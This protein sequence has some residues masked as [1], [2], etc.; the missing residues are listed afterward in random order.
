M[1]A[2]LLL[3]HVATSQIITTIAGTGVAAFSGDGG[4]ATAAEIQYPGGVLVDGSGNVY[5]SDRTNQRIRKIATTVII[6]TIAGNG[7]FSGGFGG[8]TGD[9]GPATAAELNYPSTFGFDPAGNM[10]IGDEQNNRLRKVNTSGIISTVAGTGTGTFNLASGPATTVNI[11]GPKI[12]M[13]NAG[14]IYVADK[15]QRIRKIDPAGML[16]TICGHGT[17]GFSGDGGP[18]TAAVFDL[19]L[20]VA[21]DPMGNIYFCDLG[22]IRVRKINTSGIISTVAG[23]GTAGFS[24]DG[25]PA[26]ACQLNHPSELTVDFLGNLYISDGYNTRIR[27]VNTAGIITTIAGIGIGG[28]SGDG[29]PATAADIAGPQGLAVDS[30]GNLYFADYGN[31]RIRKISSGNHIPA[32]AGGHAQ[33]LKV[34]KNA[35]A[36]VID[37]LLTIL[38]ADI[39]QTEKWTLVSGPFHGSA[40]VPYTTTSTGS[41][42]MPTGLSYTPATGY[43]GPDTFTVR[44][45]DNISIGFTTIYVNVAACLPV[46]INVPAAANGAI[47]MYPNP[48]NDELTI[49]SESAITQVV[50]TDIIGQTL[51]NQQHNSQQVTVNVND[52][53]K[54]IYLININGSLL[55]FVKQ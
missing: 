42:I 48:A 26:T 32:F 19:P 38:D 18:A 33:S 14:N 8:F 46:E 43:S 4:P 2:L 35:P 34:C 27:K 21:T 9:G 44:I 37:T 10:I 6:T 52:L 29:G 7:Y 22:N 24:G 41:S 1:F 54:G 15:L 47:Q 16:T 5:F 49:K 53:P 39:S 50:I 25:M 36:R 51:Y 12:A 11:F 17:A 20:A 3:P 30:F 40:T 45:E 55:R 28:F 23:N 31:H 13:D